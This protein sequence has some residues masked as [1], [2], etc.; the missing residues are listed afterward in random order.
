[1]A[2]LSLL[3][4]SCGLPAWRCLSVRHR[5]EALAYFSLYN[6]KVSEMSPLLPVG[7]PVGKAE[8]VLGP[9]P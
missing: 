7:G 2:M 4:W 1:M 3:S 8:L 6:P 9:G 5:D